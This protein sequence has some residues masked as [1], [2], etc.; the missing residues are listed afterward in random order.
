MLPWVADAS[1][2]SAVPASTRRRDLAIIA[3]CGLL[4]YGA[5]V[6]FWIY[7]D[8]ALYADYSLRRAFDNV[9]LHLGYYWLVIAAEATFGRLLHIPI[10]QTMAWLS[11]TMGAAVLCV[12]YVLAFDLFKS[13]TI[14]VV[15]VIIFAVSGRMIANSTTSEVYM[16]QTLFVLGSFVWFVR[17]KIVLSAIAAAAAMLVSPLSVFAFLFYPVFDYQRTARIRWSVLVKL[18]VIALACYSPY[19]IFRGHELL[20]GIRGL[21]V[22]SGG[23]PTEPMTAARNFP[24]YQFKQFTAM[25][26]LFLPLL[27]ALKK[28]RSIIALSAAVA[29]PHLYVILK[30]T[31]EDNVFIFN[32]DFFFSLL[33]ALGF[34]ELWKHRAVKWIGPAAVAAHVGTLIAA[35]SL[36]GVKD[37]KDYAGE[38]RGGFDTYLRGKNAHAITDWG[39]AMAFIFFARDSAATDL[40]LEPLIHRIFDLDNQPD[41]DSLELAG[42]DLYVIDRWNPTPLNRLLS[43]AA[44]VEE[45]YQKNSLRYI[46]ERRLNLTCTLLQERTNR[47]YRCTRKF[48]AGA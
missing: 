36:F 6:D 11:V 20:F 1:A 2:T 39:T 12:G 7:G 8:S 46:A 22:I 27:F 4:L 5:N 44:S 26:V 48:A 21:L 13:R 23:T 10:E 31:G 18:G 9:T 29:I 19:L 16:A 42:K 43:S 3:V 32:T 28:Y 40:V 37:H 38:M 14:A 17:E 33:L 24:K 15:T 41:S 47:W 45:Q 35:G 30:L 34:S 25:L